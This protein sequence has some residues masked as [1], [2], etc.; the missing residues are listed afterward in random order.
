MTQLKIGRIITEKQVSLTGVTCGMNVYKW[1]KLT[2]EEKAISFAHE[3]FDKQL[4]ET[5]RNGSFFYS[6][7][8]IGTVLIPESRVDKCLGMNND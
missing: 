3:L 2:D 8:S 1:F 7:V 6:N 5:K 4:E